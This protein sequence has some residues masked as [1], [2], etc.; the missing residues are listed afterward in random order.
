M[1]FIR[2]DRTATP[3]GA[4]TAQ[5]ATTL[6]TTGGLY[7]GNLPAISVPANENVLVG[8]VYASAI[9]FTQLNRVDVNSFKVWDPKLAGT[10]GLGAYQSFSSTNNWDPIPG[11]GSYGS[12]PN[13]RIESGQAFIVSSGTGGSIALTEAAKV[14]EAT[15]TCL[16][17]MV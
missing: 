12:A 6:R 5:S 16:E 9:D 4:A 8:N 13:T 3:T 10:S 17:Q 14:S 15:I 7:Q 2:G 1:A 11:G